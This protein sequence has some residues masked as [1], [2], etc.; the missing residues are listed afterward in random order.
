MSVSVPPKFS[1][2]QQGALLLERENF[3]PVDRT[4][5]GGTR[6]ATV[7][8][9]LQ[10][11]TVGESWE[12]SVEPQFPS[13]VT[14]D[15][16]LLREWLE[17]EPEIFLGSEHHPGCA[18]LVKLLD[19]ADRLSLQIHP[20]GDEPF[21]AP[22][23]SGKPESWLVLDAAPGAGIYLGLAEGTRERDMRDALRDETPQLEELLHFE[24]VRRG[25]FFR[26]DA[27]TPHAIGEG[28]TLVEPQR[29]EP[30]K[31]GLTYRYFD[32]GRR[33]DASGRP[34]PAGAPRE[35]HVE[36]ALA[37]T[38]WA[39]KRGSELIAEVK[40][41]T[42]IK[43]DSSLHVTPLLG[44]AAPLPSNLL[45]V[46]NFQGT[47]R[48][49]IPDAKHLRGLTVLAGRATIANSFG[50]TRLGVGQSAVLPAAARA[51]TLTGEALHAVLCAAP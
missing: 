29:V 19:T 33:Y 27:G 47:G 14:H 49:Q 48:V 43:V 1:A 46:E 7:F 37:V 31:R 20:R 13:R 3:T 24:P 39:A 11:R 18:L 41:H 30:A 15:Q 12:V 42:D 25:D 32:W 36:R 2:L 23:E 51:T 44:A 17:S 6:I 21:L 45:H 5:W 9:G 26:I 8:K 22:D 38:D 4:P 50:S 34:D 35:L 40:T 16:R 10:P 28:L